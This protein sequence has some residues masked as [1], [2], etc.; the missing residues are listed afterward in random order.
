[1]SEQKTQ[2]EWD[3]KKQRRIP[4]VSTPKDE[5]FVILDAVPAVDDLST[6]QAP[7]IDYFDR[8]EVSQSALKE[9]KKSPRHCYVKYIEKSVQT[10]ETDAMR[11]GTLVHMALFE[12]E[13]FINNCVVIPKVDKRTKAGKELYAKTVEENQGK[14]IVDIEDYAEAI[15]IRDAILTK[16]VSKIILAGGI[17][18]YEFYW[19]DDETGLACKGKADYFFEPS[20]K[21]PNGLI[22]DL[23]SCADVNKFDRSIIDYGYYIQQGWYCHGVKKIYNTKDYPAFIFIAA[24]KSPPYEA[25]FY[26]GDELMLDIGIKES[27][28]LLFW[29]KQCK[30]TGVWPG[31]A[32]RI[33]KIGLPSWFVNKFNI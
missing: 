25:A 18:E 5:P 1:M 30:D 13:K 28:Q 24:E 12:P 2:F 7:I 21:F 9:L 4:V 33:E 11:F 14:T 31:F 19:I 20:D 8:P 10:E 16:N 29:Y 26:A 3:D 6:T 32:D 17:P 22:V 15:A 23:K 27:R